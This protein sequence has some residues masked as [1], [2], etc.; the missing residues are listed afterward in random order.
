MAQATLPLLIEPRDL[1]LPIDARSTRLVDLCS[2]D[3]YLAGHIPGA[4]H[5]TP[6]RT[7]SPAPRPGPLPGFAELQ[8]I[9]SELGHHEDLHY[10]V[11]DDEGG[12]WA[13]RFIWMLDCIGHRHYS[14]ING[15]LKAWIEDGLALETAPNQVETSVPQLRIDN[16]HTITLSSLLADLRNPD[17]VIWDARSPQE[18]RGEKVVASKGGHIPGAINFE[19]TAGMDPARG[20][21]LH[22]DLAEQL[23]QLG[24]VPDKEVVTHC[25]TH[26]RSGFTYLAAKILGYPRVKA[27]AGSWSEWGNHPDTPVES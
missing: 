19:W 10:I 6:S 13:G 5:L 25:Q 16:S 7:T 2:T 1:A 11:Y 21:R 27:Y 20:L 17:R 15:G 24:I 12:G 4:V 14:Y 9:F 18:Y 26:H 8:A 23:Q 22:A 3:Q